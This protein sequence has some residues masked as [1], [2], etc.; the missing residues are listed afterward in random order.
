[1]PGMCR[2]VEYGGLGFDY[3]L[4]MAIPDMWIKVNSSYYHYYTFING[5][6]EL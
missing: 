1:M 6:R 4:A 3:R 5:I 2:E